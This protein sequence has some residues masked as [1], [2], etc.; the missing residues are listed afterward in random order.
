MD[1]HLFCLEDWHSNGTMLKE[2]PHF[3]ASWMMMANVRCLQG[4]WEK[5]PPLQKKTVSFFMIKLQLINLIV[6]KNKL[7]FR[8]F[9]ANKT[10]LL[11]YNQIENKMQIAG[12]PTTE[13]AQIVE[14]VI[15]DPIPG[16]FYISWN[17]NCMFFSLVLDRK[18]LM[19]DITI[20]NSY[21]SKNTNNT[22]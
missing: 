3:L 15:R 11:V 8:K 16:N 22:V 18:I 19:F 13:K 9:N 21:S 2:M 4:W 6:L 14:P 5:N 20:F 17:H 1:L 10:I 12:I 7:T